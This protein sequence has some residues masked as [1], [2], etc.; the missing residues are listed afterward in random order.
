MLLKI[1]EREFIKSPRIISKSLSR[2]EVRLLGLL[3]STYFY[4]YDEIRLFVYDGAN[5]PNKQI[6]NDI[7]KLENKFLLKLSINDYG[8]RLRNKIYVKE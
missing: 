8:A 3:S 4:K 6:Q 1:S 2:T 5:I 7:E